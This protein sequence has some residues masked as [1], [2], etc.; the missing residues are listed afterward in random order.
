M[1]TSYK[2]HWMN[3]GGGKGESHENTDSLFHTVVILFFID[4]LLKGTNI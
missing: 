3:T 1:Q 2:T 4:R